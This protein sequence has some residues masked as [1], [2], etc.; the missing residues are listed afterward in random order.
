MNVWT[1]VLVACMYR[2]QAGRTTGR[3]WRIADSTADGS[4]VSCQRQSSRS[5]TIPRPLADS[6]MTEHWNVKSNSKVNAWIHIA[7]YY[8]LFISKALRYGP[9]VTMGSH[10]FTATHTRTIPA[11]YSPAATPQGVTA[12]RLVLIPMERPCTPFC[13]MSFSHM[14]L[15]WL[16]S[17]STF[18]FKFAVRVYRNLTTVHIQ[19]DTCL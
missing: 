17:C 7:L 4:D 19:N 6:E 18:A 2:S 5:M 1:S 8:K 10:S 12:L 16:L 3:S 11:S 9:C 14:E 15:T 13:G